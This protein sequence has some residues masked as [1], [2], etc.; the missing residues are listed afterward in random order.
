MATISENYLSRP[1]SLSKQGGRELVYDVVGT[2]DEA[3]VE[4]L[5]LAT[6][7]ATY[8]G[9]ELESIEA[10]PVGNGSWKGYA[11]YVR[12]NDE[13]YTFSTGGG[14]ERVTQSLETVDSYAP[15]GMTAP[16][17]GGAIGVT[18]DRVEGVDVPSPKYEFSET[19]YLA[20]ATVTQSY[21]LA[22]FALTG[23]V[24]DATFRGFAAGECLFLGANGSKRGD[25]RWGITYHFACQP[26]LTGL[27]VGTITGIAKK[28]WEYL[29]VRYG[30]FEDTAAY[31]LVQRPTAAYVERVFE[32]GDFSDLG[33]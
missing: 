30:T 7:P 33:I 28:G 15:A 24:N 31:Q 12:I 14:S 23:R 8:G 11:R 16:D 17:F 26:N 25:E 5:L 27:S 1:F 22:L 4:T 29:W 3:A 20:D 32:S 18:D 10:E 2:D 9:L 21:K 19:H 6:A 13:E